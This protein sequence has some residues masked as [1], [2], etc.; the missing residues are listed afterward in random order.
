MSRVIDTVNQTQPSRR[1]PFWVRLYG[2]EQQVKAASNG[3]DDCPHFSVDEGIGKAKAVSNHQDI[4]SFLRADP[5][6]S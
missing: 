4:A 5:E 2:C 3:I 1:N 6:R